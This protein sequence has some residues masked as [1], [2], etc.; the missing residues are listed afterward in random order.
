[1][2]SGVSMTVAMNGEVLRVAPEFRLV[3]SGRFVVAELL[4][5]HRVISTSP[6]NGGQ[7]EGL[8]YLVNHQSCEGTDHRERHA[9]I[10]GGEAYH[11]SSCGEIEIDPTV[12]ASMQTAANMNYAAVVAASDLNDGDG[13]GDGRG[14]WECGLRG[15]S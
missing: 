8:R 4:V 15:R 1:M 6:K 2:E 3:R 11:D 5:A 7:R 9:A 14:A 13:G 12:S 10:T